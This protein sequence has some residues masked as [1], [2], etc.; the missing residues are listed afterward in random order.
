MF[1]EALS[2]HCTRVQSAARHAQNAHKQAHA[3]ARARAHARTHARTHA[4]THA[5]NHPPTLF[6]D[7]GG[8][9]TGMKQGMK[10]VEKTCGI[11]LGIWGMVECL[12]GGV[13]D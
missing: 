13:A 7:P 1:R 11:I 5:P 10:P 6:T 8:Y 9:E 12:Y 2:E 3:R 4:S